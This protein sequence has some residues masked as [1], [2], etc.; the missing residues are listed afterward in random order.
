MYPQYIV[1]VISL[2]TKAS[3]K[4]EAFYY[5]PGLIG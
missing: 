2:N 4:S 1:K 3:D 5:I